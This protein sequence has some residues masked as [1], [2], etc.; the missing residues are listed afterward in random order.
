MKWVVEEEM[1][2]CNPDR[3][4]CELIA[5]QF[6]MKCLALDRQHIYIQR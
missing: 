1:S 6:T 2:K 4:A 3:V 5:R